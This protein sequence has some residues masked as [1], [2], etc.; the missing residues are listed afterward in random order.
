MEGVSSYQE[1]VSMAAQQL[2]AESNGNLSYTFYA[3]NNDLMLIVHANTGHKVVD[4]GKHIKVTRDGRLLCDDPGL[5]Y[6]LEKR[7]AILKKGVFKG[8]ISREAPLN[9]TR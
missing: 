3:S 4:F 1:L 5:T 8:R 2:T 6:D 9:N 7:V